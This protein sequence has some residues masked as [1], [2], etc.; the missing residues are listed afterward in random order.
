M[1]WKRPPAPFDPAKYVGEILLGLPRCSHRVVALDAAIDNTFGCTYSL[2]A[3]ELLRW[4][5]GFSSSVMVCDEKSQAT[6]TAFITWLRS[7]DRHASDTYSR[8]PRM[9]YE[10]YAGYAVELL[11]S[12]E[13][14]LFCPQCRSSYASA[15][16][17]FEDSKSEG[18]GWLS[19]VEVWQCPKG[20][21][22][23]GAAYR[24]HLMVRRD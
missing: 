6:Q 8:V 21:R 15:N 18:G 16:V 10:L 19:G 4:F 11:Q 22:L 2:L 20:H 23:R 13:G 24:G 7:A 3:D 12:T 9:F 14:S 1:F 17:T 5:E